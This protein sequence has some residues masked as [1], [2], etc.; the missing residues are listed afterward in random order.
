MEST[1][2]YSPVGFL[3]TPGGMQRK[4]SYK[5]KEAVVKTDET[6]IRVESVSLGNS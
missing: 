2:G 1:P 4:K 3:Y 5:R 6:Y